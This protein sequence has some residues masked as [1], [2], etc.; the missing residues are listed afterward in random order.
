MDAPRADIK[1]EGHP[2]AETATAGKPLRDRHGRP[3]DRAIGLARTADFGELSDALRAIGMEPPKADTPQQRDAA[4][5]VIVDIADT[6]RGRHGEDKYGRSK[7]GWTA[8]S[9]SAEWW[10]SAGSEYADSVGLH[11][12]RAAVLGC[13]QEG[14][15]ADLEIGKRYA[16]GEQ[17]SL[18]QTRF[19]A[20]P[21]LA[22]IVM[23]KTTYDRGGRVVRLRDAA[24]R[25]IAPGNSELV[26]RITKLL[27]TVNEA[28]RAALIEISGEC[29]RA[30]VNGDGT[31][32]FGDAGHTVWTDATDLTA[33]YNGGYHLGGRFFSGWWQNVSK[34]DRQHFVID[35][36]RCVEIDHEFLHP[37]MVYAMHGL[38]LVA[39]P[40]VLPGFEGDR[41]ACKVAFNTLL[42]AATRSEAVGAVAAFFQDRDDRANG[43]VR[44]KPQGK[45]AP[46]EPRWL[47]VASSLVTAV[48]RA[49]PLV[50]DAF[51]TGIGLRLQNHDAQM[52]AEVLR[53][54]V[55]KRGIVCLPIHDSCI[56]REEHKETLAEAMYRA[57]ERKLAALGKIG[58][59]R[60]VA[61]GY[62]G[63]SLHRGGGGAGAGRGSRGWLEGANDSGRDSHAYARLGDAPIDLSFIPDFDAAP[64]TGEIPWQVAP[65]LPEERGDDGSHDGTTEILTA[66]AAVSYSLD[67]TWDMPSPSTVT[68][69]DG[70][71]SQTATGT[72]ESDM[73]PLGTVR[74]P[75]R[76]EDAPQAPAGAVL[77]AEA[78]QGNGQPTGP[79]A[80]SPV[81]IVRARPRH[82]K[83]LLDLEAK[84]ERDLANGVI[85]DRGR[86][87]M[88]RA[89]R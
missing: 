71:A 22:G 87:V 68:I 56:V 42:N 88:R 40:Y 69:S 59:S 9:F 70:T 82:P 67:E 54:L 7:S 37:K 58:N 6:A 32:S 13:H 52:L 26:H 86:S 61:G 20:S 5:R 62:R 39:D 81:D 41:L 43:I 77:E 46:L 63:Q 4:S 17:R 74:T 80:T 45:P 18:V 33:V 24:G 75:R 85:D 23:P 51:G 28:N 57:L 89:S 3:D 11:S 14:L 8:V 78:P 29:V 83:F 36:G 12:V 19:L 76:Q 30:R 60:S 21:D 49:H 53:E 16:K 2:P 34:G 50:T 47:S 35:G 72:T 64:G 84:R 73:R 48:Y 65:G 38:P 27:G 31:I 44:W 66:P 1:S 15:L 10:K 55:V 79:V 25:P